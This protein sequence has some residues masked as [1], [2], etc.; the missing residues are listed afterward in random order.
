MKSKNTQKIVFTL[1]TAALLAFIFGNSAA[2]G[3]TSSDFSLLVTGWLNSALA[4]VKIP[5]VLSH[6]FVR[7]LAHFSEYSLLGALLTATVNA[8]RRREWKFRAVWLPLVFG[9]VTASLDEYLQTFVE[10]RFG[11]PLDSLLDFSGVL[12]AALAVSAFLAVR[13]KKK[14][15]EGKLPTT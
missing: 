8:W 14:A 9:L 6:H 15:E 5:L 7:K 3:D 2:D 13:A 1:L 12:W 11:T 10:D 4:A